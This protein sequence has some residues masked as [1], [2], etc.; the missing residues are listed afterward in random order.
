MTG[1][2]SGLDPCAQYASP[3]A[4]NDPGWVRDDPLLSGSSNFVT[5]STGNALIDMGASGVT[6][7]EVLVTAGDDGLGFDRVVCSAQTTVPPGLQS[8]YPSVGRRVRRPV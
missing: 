8:R 1:L 2:Y 6:A 4:A 7:S 5:S 3:L